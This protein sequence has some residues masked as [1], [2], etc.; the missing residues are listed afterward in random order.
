MDAELVIAAR[1]GDRAAFAALVER[2]RPALL[3]AC[4]GS[5]DAAQEAVLLALTSLPALR[6]DD[7]FGPWLC[8]IGRNLAPPR[9][10]ATGVR[11]LA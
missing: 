3:R 9:N 8:G 1:A 5:A 7:A 10:R 11:P 6:D 2:H 4:R